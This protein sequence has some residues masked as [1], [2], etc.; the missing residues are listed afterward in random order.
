MTAQ[1]SAPSVPG[2]SAKCKSAT[3]AVRVRYGS[4]TASFAPR[5]F[6]AREM[7]LMTLTW[8]EAGLP[9]Q[10]M[11]RSASAISRGSGPIKLPAAA[12]QPESA[13]AVQIVSSWPE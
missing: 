12:F 8:V 2:R 9:P 1:A 3:A 5:S 13:S 11:I 4:T 6:R 10:E 7:W